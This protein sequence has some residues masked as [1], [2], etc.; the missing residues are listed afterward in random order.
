MNKQ[1]D[2]MDAKRHEETRPQTTSQEKRGLISFLSTFP[3]CL[4]PAA[5]LVVYILCAAGLLIPINFNF[6]TM[7]VAHQIADASQA[8]WFYAWWPFALSHGLNPL[9]TSQVWAPTGQ[10]LAWTQS[11]PVLA[12]L[13]APV[14][15]TLGPIIS[16]NLLAVAA[17]VLNSFS[18]LM[19]CRQIGAKL[20]AAALGGWLFGFS[21][22]VMAELMG[23]PNL[24]CV[25]MIPLMT[26]L[27][28][29]YM[30][31]TISPRRFTGWFSA[32]GI[33]LFLTSTELFATT[34][35]TGIIAAIA[36]IICWRDSET[37]KRLYRL[38]ACTLTSMV[39][40]GVML[41]PILYV[42]FTELG[43]QPELIHPARDFSADAANLLI[44]TR[45]LWAGGDTMA[46]VSRRFS[47]FLPEQSAYIGLPLLVL[48]GLYG[49]EFRKKPAACFLLLLLL[50]MVLL[51]LGPYLTVAGW[52]LPI[53]LPWSLLGHIP[54]LQKA[55]PA[56]LS[57]YVSLVTA[58]IA[59]WWL[60]KSRRRPAFRAALGLLVAATMFPNIAAGLWAV[61]PP[62]PSFF[63]G[64]AVR[65]SLM[66]GENI[67]ALPYGINGDSMI[68]QAET[69]FYFRL[70][71]GY[72][73]LTGPYAQQ[74]I[75]QAFYAATAPAHYHAELAAFARRFHVGAIVVPDVDKPQYAAVLKNVSHHPLHTAGV[76]VYPISSL[77]RSRK[78][79]VARNGVQK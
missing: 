28:I 48:V 47:G 65:A 32:A 57:L 9:F 53:T 73:A 44:P 37:R 7:L 14:T 66:P 27:V 63:T 1:A 50:G 38:F 36:A 4:Q 54:V 34:V 19:T 40:I 2:S 20:P 30:K 70:A 59:A 13:L 23:R 78:A 24:Y 76:W 61:R 15:L 10:S 49:W 62:N 58:L 71:G 6:S 31:N 60:T 56:R 25:W 41:S 52:N 39:V 67:V 8:M 12:L 51:S 68:W 77:R 74:T 43:R 45:T 75:P 5:V 3:Y 72:L 11:A 26:L 17:P 22:Y 69:G 64:P 42:M 18:A 33:V 35:L 16:Y 29:R 55:L 79:S 46:F 21:P